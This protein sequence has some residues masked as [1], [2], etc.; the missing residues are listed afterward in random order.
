MARLNSE[1]C[2]MLPYDVYICFG[3]WRPIAPIRLMGACLPINKL[4]TTTICFL[5]P[6]AIGDLSHYPNPTPITFKPPNISSLFSLKIRHIMI[7]MKCKQTKKLKKKLQ[8]KKKILTEL[9]GAALS[10]HK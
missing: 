5:Y 9:R 4:S 8:V 1:Y 10:Y 3:P 2:S 6:L 7:S